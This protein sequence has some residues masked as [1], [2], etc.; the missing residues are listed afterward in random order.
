MGPPG[1]RGWLSTARKKKYMYL[2]VAKNVFFLNFFFIENFFSEGS[3]FLWPGVTV[4][5]IY[6]VVKTSGFSA[7][8]Q[9]KGYL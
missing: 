2:S 8:Q 9:T 7:M 5:D 1:P 3:G 6:I 4:Q